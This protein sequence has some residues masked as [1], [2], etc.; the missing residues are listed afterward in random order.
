[1][2]KKTETWIL[3]H[4]LSSQMQQSKRVSSVSFDFATGKSKTL[5]ITGEV[6]TREISPAE[7]VM[8]IFLFEEHKEISR[9]SDGIVRELRYL[10]K[11]FEIAKNPS[12]DTDE[13][14]KNRKTI[15]FLKNHYE[16]SYKDLDGKE[17]NKN[18]KDGAKMYYQ[19]INID[20]KESQIAENEILY[21]ELVGEVIAMK[22]NEEAF[23]ELAFGLGINPVGLSTDKVFNLIKSMIAKS[24]KTFK[25]F[26]MNDND[27]VYKIVINKALRTK[28]PDSE[29]NFI[30][31]DENKNYKM[32]G[33]LLSSSYDSLILYFKENAELF[34]Y[35]QRN[36]GFKKNENPTTSKRGS[37]K[38]SEK[39]AEE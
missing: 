33:Q 25:D 20:A 18:V 1:M 11:T 13:Q 9:G 7:R 26:L 2:S 23:T 29:F 6:T 30:I 10:Q 35:L 38:K 32:N 16:V 21:N 34:E 22:E 28:M 12:D 17:Q 24:P 8:P 31:E 3:R 4:T 5:L 14:K 19:L 39:I 27:K 15:E 37:R 36:L